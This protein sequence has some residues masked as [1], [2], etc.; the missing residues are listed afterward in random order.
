MPGNIISINDW[1]EFYVGDSKMNKLA[2]FLGK[3]GFPENKEAKEFLE[4]EEVEYRTTRNYPS[5][6]VKLVRPKIV[7]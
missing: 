2:I 3:Y 1:A 5:E 6:H 7:S 4:T